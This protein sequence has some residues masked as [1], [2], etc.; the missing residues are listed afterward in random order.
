MIDINNNLS[1][2]FNRNNDTLV[3]ETMKYLEN[4]INNSE[5]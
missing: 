4:M 3:L 2:I 1:M 5:F